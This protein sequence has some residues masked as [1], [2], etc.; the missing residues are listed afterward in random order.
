MHNIIISI[1]VA[2]M[3]HLLEPHC[4]DMII[5]DSRAEYYAFP[6]HSRYSLL[7]IKKM[8]HMI[9]AVHSRPHSGGNPERMVLKVLEASTFEHE[10]IRLAELNISPCKGC[11][12][13]AQSK[14]CVQK[15]SDDMHLRALE[16]L[17]ATYP[18]LS[19][20]DHVTLLESTWHKLKPFAGASEAIDRLRTKYT[21]IVL[22]IL[23]WKSIVRSS[24]R[25]GIQWDGI[26]SCE[27]LGYYKPSLQAYLRGVG[28]LG[29]QPEEAMMVAAH[30]GDL[31]AAQAAGL[32]TAL[33]SVPEE[34]SVDEGFGQQARPTFD[35]AARDF[36]A[37]CLQLGC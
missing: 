12:G 13:W 8:R 5:N 11:V 4:R 34:D 25:A 27:F 30:E 33:V 28:L 32:K 9:L 6:G 36:Q 16:H 29:L 15:D 35:A 19:S 17:A 31:A 22:T 3:E 37:L 14:R 1:L 24:K 20:V 18:F 7:L 23:S 2:R 26:L 10:L 21:V